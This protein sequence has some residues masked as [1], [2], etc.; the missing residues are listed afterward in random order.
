MRLSPKQNKTF[1]IRLLFSLPM[2]LSHPSRCYEPGS[3]HSWSLFSIKKVERPTKLEGLLLFLRMKSQN[4]IKQEGD[5]YNLLWICL[6][7]SGRQQAKWKSP[8]EYDWIMRVADGLFCWR[9]HVMKAAATRPNT[10]APG[11]WGWLVSLR[12]L[13]SNC[14]SK[15]SS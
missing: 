12:F 6:L 7:D 9:C 2:L 4:L 1:G 15:T 13:N 11:L 5:V 8:L 3:V 14:C 10:W